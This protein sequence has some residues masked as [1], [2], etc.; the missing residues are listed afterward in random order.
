ML[1]FYWFPPEVN[2]WTYL[3]STTLLSIVPVLVYYKM[4]IKWQIIKK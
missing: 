4:K 3:I 1:V 2:K